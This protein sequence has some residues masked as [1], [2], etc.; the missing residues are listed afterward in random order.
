[1]EAAEQ[2][3]AKGE[4]DDDEAPP[5]GAR[6]ALVVATAEADPEFADDPDRDQA[7]EDELGARV[8]VGQRLQTGS[9]SSVAW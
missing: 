4:D 9:A 5:L 2:P 6:A 1:V 3:D 7:D 8:G